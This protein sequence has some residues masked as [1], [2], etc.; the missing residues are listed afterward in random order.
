M[1]VADP[2]VRA[3]LDHQGRQEAQQDHGQRHRPGGARR[4]ATA[5]TPCAT[6]SCARA[7]YG[8]DWDFTDQAFVTRYNADLANDLGNLVSRALTMVERYCGGKVPPAAGRASG[9]FEASFDAGRA[10]DADARDRYEALDFAGALDRGLELGRPSCNQAHRRQSRPGSWPRTP[11][12][13]GELDAFLY[14]L[15]EA[16]R[17]IA[18]LASPGHAARRAAASSRC[19]GF[20]ERAA[21]RRPRV[22]PPRAGRAARRDRAALPARIEDR[23]KETRVRAA[24]R[25]K[26]DRRRV[27]RPTQRRAAAH[28]RRTH[29]HRRLREGRAARGAGSRRPRRSRARRSS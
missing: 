11:A 20:G 28:G 19:S 4:P 18:V 15:L 17:L 29:R 1:P 12:R 16:V 21:A 3:G 24:S 9:R 7:T 27:P 26:P 2:R 13:R 14:R 8:Q 5:P 25:R 6:S 23:S 22:G 10:R